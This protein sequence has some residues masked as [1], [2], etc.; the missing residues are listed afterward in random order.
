[1]KDEIIIVGRTGDCIAEVN[2]N[3]WQYESICY[4]LNVEGRDTDLDVIDRY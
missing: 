4:V 2:F 3:A 1:M